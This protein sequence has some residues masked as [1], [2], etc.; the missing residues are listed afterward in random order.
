MTTPVG[1]VFAVDPLTPAIDALRAELHHDEEMVRSV[2]AKRL[3]FSRRRSSS[4]SS[5]VIPSRWSLFPPQ[6][7]ERFA[8]REQLG[9][10]AYAE[11][12]RV[13]ERATGK[14]WAVKVVFKD[15][16]KDQRRLDTEME[17]LRRAKHARI[18]CL[19]ETFVETSH[20]YLLQDLCASLAFVVCDIDALLVVCALAFLC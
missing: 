15:R 3:S 13:E 1:H 7:H 5:S 10:G 17:A 11:V 18:I 6:F 8:V 4:S 16:V 20:L 19:V 9:A 12:H 14:Q 2:A